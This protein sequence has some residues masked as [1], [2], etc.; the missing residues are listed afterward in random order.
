MSRNISV[1][2]L[3]T[4]I[5]RQLAGRFADVSEADA[6]AAKLSQSVLK[7]ICPHLKYNM[8]PDGYSQN[9]N[10]RRHKHARQTTQLV[11]TAT[12]ERK[13]PTQQQQQQQK[14][15]E[16]GGYK[17]HLRSY[18]SRIISWGIG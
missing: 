15:K 17:D 9:C 12:T 7:E 11:R 14:E 3:R 16:N 1:E 2:A 8:T 4:H 10:R 6:I 5:G 13:L 18:L